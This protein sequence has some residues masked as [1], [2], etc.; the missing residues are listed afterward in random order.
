MATAEDLS[1][2]TCWTWR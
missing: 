2:W 1:T